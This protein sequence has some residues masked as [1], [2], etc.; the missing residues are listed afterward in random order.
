MDSIDF[1]GLFA[2]TGVD[3]FSKEADAFLAPELMLSIFGISFIN[4]SVKF[5]H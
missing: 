2:F 4:K 3:I 5:F 1:R